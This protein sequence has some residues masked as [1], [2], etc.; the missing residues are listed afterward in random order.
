VKQTH[1]FFGSKE[2]WCGKRGIEIVKILLQTNKNLGVKIL[3][4]TSCVGLFED[5]G[6]RVAHLTSLTGS[7]FLYPKRVIVAT[8][9]Q[10][11]MILFKNNDLP[12]IYGAGAVQTLVNVYG[13]IPGKKVLMI[14]SGNIGLIVSYQLIQAGIE[15][16]KVVEILPKITGYLVHASKL[17]RLGVDICTSWTIKEAI[18]NDCVEGAIICRVDKNLNPILTEE[19]KITCD[20]ICI[21]AGLS[22]SFELLAQ[23]G[24]KVVYIREL[25]GYVPWH[26]EK[27]QTSIEDIYVAGDTAGV[28][29][30]VS[31]IIEG[32]VAGYMCVLDIL[33][34]DKKVEKLVKDCLVQLEEFRENQFGEKVKVGKKKMKKGGELC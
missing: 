21:S 9:A 22:P 12:G 10:E 13:I 2:Y 29:E 26:N 11:K 24:C 17:K 8:G 14:G 31:A 32:K 1:K 20:T 30:A 5:K 7:Y 25:G 15:V 6:K 23:V 19:E 3:P 27:M 28:E 34:Q 4:N 33:G 18:G 16:V